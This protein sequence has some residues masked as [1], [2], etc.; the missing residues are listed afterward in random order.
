MASDS[1]KTFRLVL[2][3]ALASEAMA[4]L[5]TGVF[6]AGFLVQ[7]G[8]S[9]LAIGMLAAVPFAGSSCNCPRSCWLSACGRAA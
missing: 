9:N 8:A 5:T 1:D 3:D 4:T 7:L 2:Y 6:L